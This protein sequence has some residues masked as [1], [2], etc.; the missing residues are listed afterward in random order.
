[1]KNSNLKFTATLVSVLLLSA[2]SLIAQ[3]KRE[4]PPTTAKATV[5][6]T[7][8]TINY[9][10][11]SVKGRTIW[12]GLVPYGKV[13][14]TGAN[15]ATTIEV[16]A[17]IA[18]GGNLLKKGKYSLFT[19]PGKDEWIIIINSNPGQWGAFSYDKSKDVMRLTSKPT[20]NEAMESFTISISESGTVS[21]VWDKIKADFKIG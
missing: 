11:P 6:G 13:W 5:N 18:V 2:F 9:S 17:D 19:I 8:I 16:S 1:M 10:S 20:E 21:L 14:R 3:K 12:G 15:E 4:S 7:E